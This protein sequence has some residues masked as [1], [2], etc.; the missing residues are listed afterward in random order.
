MGQAFE[1]ACPIDRFFSPIVVIS[2]PGPFL[3]KVMGFA[4]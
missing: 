1:P 2:T 4:D 3:M